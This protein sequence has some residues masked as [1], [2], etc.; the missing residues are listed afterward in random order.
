METMDLRE[1]AEVE[2]LEYFDTTNQRNGYPSHI[3]GAIK[4]FDT[5]E[6]AQEIAKKYDLS[7]ESFE[8]KDGWSLWYRTGN[9]MYEEFENSEKEYGDDYDSFAGCSMEEDVFIES[10]VL[11]ILQDCNSPTTQSFE[12]IMDFIKDKQQV[13][14]EIW[15]ASEDELVITNCGQYFETIKKRS[16]AFYHDTHHYVIG[17]INID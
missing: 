13:F 5:F 6:Q 16:M 8:K 14:D 7:I 1:I 15:K 2:G 12:S 3:K 9:R 11:P 10:E 17:V 4:G